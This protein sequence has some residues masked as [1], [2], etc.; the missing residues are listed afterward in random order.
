MSQCLIL[1]SDTPWPRG[2]D[3]RFKVMASGYQ[4]PL[5]PYV[6]ADALTKGGYTTS[7]LDHTGRDWDQ[8]WALVEP[9]LDC[10]TLWVGIS[11]TFS[12]QG[13]F[14]LL[15]VKE[16]WR[17]VLEFMGRV[18]TYSP[19]AQF[20]AGG[21]FA[22]IW[23]KLGWTVFLNH[24]DESLIDWTDRLHGGRPLLNKIIQGDHNQQ[25]L[26]R[27]CLWQGSDSP[28]PGEAL[29]LEISRGCRFRC[30][31]CRYH[32]NGRSGGDYI[33][34]PQCIREEMEYAYQQWG[35]VQ[36]TL[37][38]DTFNESTEKLE[39]LLG[40]LENLSF[41]PRLTAYIRADLLESQPAQVGLLKDLGLDNAMFG[42][43]TLNP[44]NGPLIGKSRPPART[45]DFIADLKGGAWSHVGLHSG[46][47]LGL[48]WDQPRTA[49]EEF[50]EWAVS[51]NCP[52]DS[53]SL[54]ALNI[55]R[56]AWRDG[57][58]QVKTA[59][60]FDL[61]SE[62]WGYVWQDPKEGE[63]TNMNTGMT[64]SQAHADTGWASL[65]IYER[66]VGH[67]IAGFNYNRLLNLGI[68]AEELKNSHIK[69]LDAKWD[70]VKLTEQRHCP[71]SSS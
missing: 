56:P 38:D 36:W 54:E 16:D 2:T 65:E 10:T 59:S 68:P 43:E 21:Y 70:L 17:K 15:D 48:P 71:A 49:A 33:R 7:V 63:W 34:D 4:R 1:W 31:F 50:V 41:Q 12:I 20:L 51:S 28:Q 42:I 23:R 66:G 18:R 60:Q 37:A 69:Q 35:T 44:R 40:A 47:I 19:R 6:I 46:F 25:F 8:L 29:T 9:H 55:L 24:S 22:H 30:Q 52:L 11:T 58:A 45:L 53:V 39:A 3:H 26:T 13:C 27:P 14:G 57:W 67:R 62:R 5:G 32:L 64:A 61:D